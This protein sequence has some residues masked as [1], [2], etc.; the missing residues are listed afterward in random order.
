MHHARS[1]I[2]PTRSAF[3]GGLRNSP[4]HTLCRCAA[5]A[6]ESP[7][8]ANLFL[9]RSLL[10]SALSNPSWLRGPPFRKRGAF[11]P[12]ARSSG[13]IVLRSSSA[14]A[15]RHSLFQAWPPSI[16]SR[17]AGVILP[18]RIL[19][20]GNPPRQAAA[21]RP[22]FS[23]CPA[24]KP[25]APALRFPGRASSAKTIGRPAPAAPRRV[26]PGRAVREAA[27]P[28]PLPPNPPPRSGTLPP[29]LFVARISPRVRRRRSEWFSSF[30]FPCSLT[31]L[32]LPS[33]A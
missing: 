12:S 22:P 3:P 27:L 2:I 5:I 4:Q 29:V 21:L 15:A 8:P 31:F 7:G 20:P 32:L 24:P 33:A 10:E 19:S 6:R 16:K 11:P 1:Q 25:S 17:R 30:V 18:A 14:A 23:P 28:V 13:Q 26:A 9:R